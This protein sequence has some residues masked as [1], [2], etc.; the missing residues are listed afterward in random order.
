M[1]RS[2]DDATLGR[3]LQHFSTAAAPVLAALATAPPESPE[4]SGARAGGVAIMGRL[5]TV[6]AR[7]SDATLDERAAWWVRTVGQLN[8]VLVASSTAAVS[9]VPAAE[10]VPVTDLLAA[11]GEGLVVCGIAREYGVAEPVGQARLLAAVLLRRRIDV[12]VEPAEAAVDGPAEPPA[13]GRGTSALARDAL[14]LGQ[15]LY[16]LTAEV[17]DGR[18]EGKGRRGLLQRVPGGRA[19]AEYKSGRANLDRVA[20]EARE[21]LDGYVADP[22]NRPGLLP[23]D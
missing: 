21:W 10:K 16:R 15:T 11:A 5:A 12:P 4:T 19:L 8:A 17:R 22:A 2:V 23:P 1:T 3:A 14:R 7:P 18:A 20:A 9:V 13:A 6:V